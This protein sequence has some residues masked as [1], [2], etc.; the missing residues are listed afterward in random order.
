MPARIAIPARYPAVGR[1]PYRRAALSWS[2]AQEAKMDR[3]KKD[4][5]VGQAAAGLLPGGA[6]H[7]AAV[8]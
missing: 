5:C 8:A 7:G 3:S 6:G 1:Y 2:N 4:Y